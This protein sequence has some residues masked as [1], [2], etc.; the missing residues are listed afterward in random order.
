LGLRLSYIGNKATRVP[1][2]TYQ[3]NL[4]VVQAPG[5][6]QSQRPYQPWADISTLDTNGDSITHQFQAEITRRFQNG[7]FL[8]ANYT[9]NKTLDDV[10][11]ASSPQNPY[12]VS[13]DRGNG[14]A[15]RPQVF[16]LSSTYDL[17]FGPG[18]HFVSKGGVAGKIIGGWGLAGIL[19]LR[20]GTPFSVNFSPT[21]AGWYA[22]RAD[23][24][25]S[26]VYPS[27]QSISQWFNPAAFA[28]PTPFTFGNSARNMLFGPGQK[29]LDMSILKTTKIG[30]RI[31]TEFRAEFFNMPNHPSFSNPAS[32]ISV[33]ATVGRITSTSVDPRAIQFGLKLLF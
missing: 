20:A 5:T 12:K 18:K 13:A 33:P 26:K 6:I 10:P 17:P 15:I 1:W 31:A 24:V 32:N 19:Q 7:L 16:Y 9:W 28:T 8:T 11:I 2:Y 21:L 25:S 4:P 29:L 23:T 22:N 3:R 30:E 27:Q 14:E